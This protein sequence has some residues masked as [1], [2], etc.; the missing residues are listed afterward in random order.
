MNNQGKTAILAFSPNDFFYYSADQTPS[1]TECK[2]IT[3]DTIANDN[4]CE[5]ADY[6]NSNNEK[7]IKMALCLNKE[8]AQTVL[9]M[10]TNSG[11]DVRL[12]D[13]NE[14][15]AEEKMTCIN[16]SLGVG[17]IAI[18]IINKMFVYFNY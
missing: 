2:T 10:Q 8:K 11:N 1:D 12:K 13:T 18:M 17:I 3:K 6:F 9:Q 7:C 4:K 5:N 15:Y 14:L 16:Y